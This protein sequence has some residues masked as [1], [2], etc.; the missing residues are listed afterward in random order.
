MNYEKFENQ[1]LELDKKKYV[2]YDIVKQIVETHK[3]NLKIN[4]QRIKIS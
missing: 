4:Q 3:K 2:I 1:K